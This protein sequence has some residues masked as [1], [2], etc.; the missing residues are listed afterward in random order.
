MN[1]IVVYVENS[2]ERYHRV[3]LHSTLAAAE[4]ARAE[5]G[6]E[7]GVGDRNGEEPI[8]YKVTLDGGP[9]ERVF[10]DDTTSITKA[11]ADG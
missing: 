4:A 3:T 11:R 6:I 7:P 9:A 1:Y 8:I 10:T 2:V 5:L